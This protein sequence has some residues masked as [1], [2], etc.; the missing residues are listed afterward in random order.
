MNQL[1]RLATAARVFGLSAVT[2]LGLMSLDYRLVLPIVVLAA[3]AAISAYMSATL[4][5]PMPTVSIT[6]AVVSGLV[7]GISLPDGAALL[8]Y[9]AA[10][11]LVAGL[12]GG[13]LALSGV[14]L[15]GLATM[16]FVLL[17]LSAPSHSVALM[18]SL[19]PWV[20]TGVGLGGLG[21]WL[22]SIGAFANTSADS[23]YSAAYR[24]VTQLRT[25]ARR[26]S[27]GLDSTLVAKE[28][29]S[30]VSRRTK[31]TD[32]G[33]FVRSDGGVLTPAAYHGAD[34][35]ELPA[36][37]RE[38]FSRC[39]TE[40]E[41]VAFADGSSVVVGL[42]MRAG[43]RLVGVVV[44]RV[45]E[46]PSV[47]ALRALCSDLEASALR[48]DT[49]LAFDHVRSIATSEERSRLAR[50]IHDGIAQEIAGLGYAVDSLASQAESQDQ[51]E[52]L[53]DLREELTRIVGELR[54]SIFDLRSE[55]VSGTG[56]GQ[57][58]S[59][60]MRN[61]GARSKLT[62]HLTL[63]EAPNRLRPEVEAELLRIVQEAT[64]NAR[65]H[66]GAKNVW[67]SCRVSPPAAEIEVRDDGSGFTEQRGDSYGLRIMEERAKRLG[68]TLE[69]RTFPGEESGG[70]VVRLA[71]PSSQR[72]AEK[73]WNGADSGATA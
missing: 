53:Q 64:T 29:C 37:E 13:L 4:A 32:V 47:L 41:P 70:T 1:Q 30:D 39:W 16:T 50:E 20:L 58:L 56:L 31:A 28:I 14:L 49:A 2:G 44:A 7:I 67:V 24:L 52:G 60:Y 48:L 21:V 72:A 68:A 6:E 71:M 43:S 8:P 65:K 69:V 45:P 23:A 12:T 17:S 46:A 3:V 38:E 55:V 66:S 9:L 19:A 54:L 26:L 25:L 10:L 15:A 57:A 73:S 51:K 35:A 63:D 42:P 5:L 33:A 34:G 27:Y 62:V 18:T 61:F 36:P 59:D 40:Q 11:C 22:R